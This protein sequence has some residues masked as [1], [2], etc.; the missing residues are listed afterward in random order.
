MAR[1]TVE[2]CTKIINNRFKLVVLSS[3]RAR[4]IASGAEIY[5]EKNNDK[6]PVIALREIAEKKIDKKIL[7]DEVISS[8]Q[9]NNRYMAKEETDS[10]VKDS[11]AEETADSKATDEAAIFAEDNIVVED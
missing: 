3:R 9:S 7:L 4:D 1:V 6:D 5:V 8:Y 2:D 11:Y 10:E